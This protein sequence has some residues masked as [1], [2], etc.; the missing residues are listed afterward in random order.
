MQ[1]QDHLREGGAAKLTE[2]IPS[3][4]PRGCSWKATIFVGCPPEM[5]CLVPKALVK[6]FRMSEAELKLQC[7]GDVLVLPVAKYAISLKQ[8]GNGG[9][10]RNIL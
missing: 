9:G 2:L 4:V 1:R 5:R 6:C 10:G 7:C 3:R 8:W